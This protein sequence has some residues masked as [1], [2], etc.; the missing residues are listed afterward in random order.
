[1]TFSWSPLESHPVR[2]TLPRHQLV[3][4]RK[5]FLASPALSTIQSPVPAAAKV[6][7]LRFAFYFCLP[8]FKGGLMLD[9]YSVLLFLINF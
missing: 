2:D 1:M 6:Q 5:G 7:L 8:T 9:F 4:R 3:Q